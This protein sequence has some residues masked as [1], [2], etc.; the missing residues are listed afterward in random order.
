M[1]F[2]TCFQGCGIRSALI[3][4]PDPDPAFLRIRIQ[5]R[6]HGF[7][8]K[9][10]GTNLK[11]KI[12]EYFFDNKNCKPS[13]LKKEHPALQNMK[14]L[15]F[16][17]ICRSFLPSW[18]RIRIQQPK[19]KRIRIHNPAC[20]M[21]TTSSGPRLPRHPTGTLRSNPTKPNPCRLFNVF[22]VKKAQDSLDEVTLLATTL[23]GDK[24]RWMLYYTYFL[25]QEKWKDR[26]RRWD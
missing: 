8:D 21:G 17:Y 13:A 11:L 10:I 2:H 5:Y 24:G 7:D 14:I 6:I 3:F 20:L 12:T 16:F 26:K 18:I 22:L 25:Y 19:S 23:N 1:Y 15:Y 9:K 4:N